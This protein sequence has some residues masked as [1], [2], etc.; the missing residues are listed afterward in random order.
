MIL[1]VE[2]TAGVLKIDD[3]PSQ[4]S[5][6]HFPGF[7]YQVGHFDER[8]DTLCSTVDIVWIRSV[9]IVAGCAICKKESTFVEPIRFIKRLA[10]L[11]SSQVLDKIP[12]RHN[13]ETGVKAVDP[14]L[15]RC[16]TVRPGSVASLLRKRIFDR[17]TRDIS[18]LVISCNNSGPCKQFGDKQIHIVDFRMIERR[19]TETLTCSV[20]RSIQ[21]VQQ[22]AASACCHVENRLATSSFIPIE[23]GVRREYRADRVRS[24]ARSKKSSRLP[25][26]VVPPARIFVVRV[27]KHAES[28]HQKLEIRRHTIALRILS[29]RKIIR[30]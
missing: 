28:V 23:A 5:A 26:E 30:Q 11:I 7:R 10:P 3:S 2:K 27:T 18:I 17:P 29:C 20:A 24:P 25:I 16:L 9:M 6:G 19:V 15:R 21:S 13:D 1:E 22:K 12:E 4:N 8:H 14:R